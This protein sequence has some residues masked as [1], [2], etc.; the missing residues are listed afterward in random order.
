MP[1]SAL[2]RV[3]AFHCKVVSLM[4]AC[5]CV[6]NEQ[7]NKSMGQKGTIF[8]APILLTS[9]VTSTALLSGASHGESSQ[10]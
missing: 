5:R 4:T 7:K 2:K 1:E 10:H 6:L 3:K 9:R 8:H